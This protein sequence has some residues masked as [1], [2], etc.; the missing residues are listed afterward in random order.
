MLVHLANRDVVRVA[1]DVPVP[2]LLIDR[3]VVDQGAASGSAH[4]RR[5][6]KR[7][8][9][10]GIFVD[11]SAFLV[12]VVAHDTIVHVLEILI[13]IFT[14]T[15]GRLLV[16]LALQL[17]GGVSDDELVRRHAKVLRRVLVRDVA[18]ESRDAATRFRSDHVA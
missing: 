11:K 4:D 1:H 9:H 10:A 13:C 17:T 5:L 2:D 7:L 3:W 8:V 12:H 14:S 16:L 18:S 6:L 15:E